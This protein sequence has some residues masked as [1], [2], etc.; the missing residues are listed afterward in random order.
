MVLTLP[1]IQAQHAPCCMA[2]AAWCSRATCKYSGQD[3][4]ENEGPAGAAA[5]KII[6]ARSENRLLE[7]VLGH[8]PL[9]NCMVL[10]DLFSTYTWPYL[11]M[12]TF[13]QL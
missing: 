10:L 6:A 8:S 3:K 12:L 5:S 7:A 11:G 2:A 4:R 9:A 13:V 1:E